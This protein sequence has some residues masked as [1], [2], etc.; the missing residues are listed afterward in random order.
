M[1]NLVKV[2]LHGELGQKF[3]E[4][5]LLSVSSVSEAINAIQNLTDGKFNKFLLQKEKASVKYRILINNEDF[6]TEKPLDEDSTI[7][8]IKNTNLVIKIN[9]LKTIDIVPIIEGAGGGLLNSILGGLLIVVGALLVIFSGGTLTY[10]GVGLIMIGAGLLAAGITALLAKPPTFD[11]FRT[12]GGGAKLSYLFNGPENVTKEGGPIP[13][14]YGKL[15]VGSQVIGASYVNKD[16]SEDKKSYANNPSKFYIWSSSY[17]LNPGDPFYNISLIDD[18]KAFMYDNHYGKDDSDGLVSQVAGGYYELNTDG[19]L[20]IYRPLPDNIIWYMQHFKNPISA[21]SPW[22]YGPDPDENPFPDATFPQQFVGGGVGYG[23]QYEGKSYPYRSWN[24]IPYTNTASTTTEK[25]E[26]IIRGDIDGI[27]STTEVEVLDLISEGP[28]EGLVDREYIFT[29]TKGNIGW[30]TATEKLY[31]DPTDTKGYRWLRSVYLNQV[32]VVDSANK[33]NFQR[34]DIYQTKGE[35]NGALLFG[36]S[37]YELNISRGISE[38]LRASELNDIGDVNKDFTKIY[39]IYNKDCKGVILNVKILRIYHTNQETGEVGRTFVDY[40]IYYR[41]F[42]SNSSKNYSA[43]KPEQKGFFGPVSER[44]EGK[45]Q[46]PYIRATKIDFPNGPTLEQDFVGWEIKVIRITPDSTSV[47]LQNQTYIDSLTEVYS[48][49]FSYPFSAIVRSRYNAEFFGSIPQRAF[50]TKLLKIKV[51]KN[52]DPITK[53]YA[54]SGDG[55]TNGYWNGEFKDELTWTDNPAWCFYDLLTNKR[56]GLGEYMEE[57]Q[58]DKFSLY[59]IARYCDTLVPDGYG[60]L[61]PRFTCNL[62][63]YTREEAYKVLNDLASIFNAMVYYANGSI[64]VSQDRPKEAVTFFNNANVENGDFNYA[65]TSKRV[66]NTVAIVRYNDPNNYYKPAIEYVQNVEGIRKY[67]VRTLEISAF[68]C[69]SKGQAARLGHW[70][71]TSELYQTETVSFVTGLE[72]QYLR[73]GD[74]FAVYDS[75]RKKYKNSGRL[76]SVTNNPTYSV[77]VINGAL[78]IDAGKTYY[79]DLVTPSYNY[80]ASQVEDLDSGDESNIRRSFVQKLEFTTTDTSYNSTL[81]QTTIT[82]ATV[83]NTTDYIV[84]IDQ[85]WIIEQKESANA[86]DTNEELNKSIAS[87]YDYYSVVRIV[88]KEDGRFEIGGVQYIDDKYESISNNIAFERQDAIVN[89]VPNV[90]QDLQLSTFDT[91]QNSKLISYVITPANSVTGL[92]SYKV[93]VSNEPFTSSDVPD[94]EYLNQTIPSI[95]NPVGTF[96]PEKAADYYFRIYGFNDEARAYSSSYVEKS[97]FIGEVQAIKDIKITSLTIDGTSNPSS[98]PSPIDNIRMNEVSPLFTWQVGISDGATVPDNIY[99]RLTF[100]EPKTG[101]QIPSSNIYYEVTGLTT[102]SYRFPFAT[103]AALNGGP[104]KNYEVI[105]EAHDSKFRTSAGN[106]IEY[107]ENSVTI[108]KYENGWINNT[109]GYDRVYVY[110]DS[111]SSLTLS[112]NTGGFGRIEDSGKNYQYIDLN[113]GV[114]ILFGYESVPTGIIG[115]V[116]YASTG[117]FTE[118]QAKTFK[119]DIVVRQFNYNQFERY[120]YAPSVFNPYTEFKTGWLAVS[121]YDTFD[122]EYILKNPNYITGLTMSNVVPIFATGFAHSLEIKNDLTFINNNKYDDKLKMFI[123][124]ISST[125]NYRFVLQE[126]GTETILM[127]RTA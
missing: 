118:A 77:V 13:V 95:S 80:D 29:G 126:G 26:G 18:Y 87:D 62:I 120:A 24:G 38:R 14:G 103:N 119:S 76:I 108:P 58:V 51:P 47:Y 122:K 1:S 78:T 110:S 40:K 98:S 69:T 64:Y 127:S 2:V 52:Y 49:I 94:T 84:Q 83:F 85:P 99:Y 63:L 73:P 8:D 30:T 82:F 16:T 27:V 112:Q 96:Y 22:F 15:L 61:E 92:T 19:S 91:T 9:N 33:Y 23:A 57:A 74:V 89:S 21:V 4:E 113:G 39:R 105:A 12:I 71:L 17:D 54:T 70:M 35:A 111:L 55:I 36:S 72:A 65:G 53:T 90:P 115:G 42:Y 20:K 102:P 59:Q 93:F 75:N 56:Y 7:E 101:E 68:G 86:I 104:Y 48:S 114:N 50:Y 124:N 116:M 81:D 125:G 28:I 5:W 10:L 43:L 46:N 106:T 79:F 6:L 121:L 32:P 60:G 100:R 88:E 97:L 67:G 34:V 31:D 123:N 3:G 107:I 41:P 66:R 25:D 45:L 11:D 109:D 117:L 44:I 37:L